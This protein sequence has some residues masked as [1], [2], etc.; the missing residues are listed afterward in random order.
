MRGSNWI[1]KIAKEG[2]W[3]QRGNTSGG[4]GIGNRWGLAGRLDST[5]MWLLGPRL[6]LHGFAH[7]GPPPHSRQLWNNTLE[8]KAKLFRV[9]SRHR[10]A[11]ASRHC[12]CPWGPTLATCPAWH[13]RYS[14]YPVLTP[15]GLLDL[16][17]ISE[18]WMTIPWGHFKRS[19]GVPAAPQG[20]GPDGKSIHSRHR[21]WW[22][23]WAQPKVYCFLRAVW[24]CA[25]ATL[26]S[27]LFMQSYADKWATD[28]RGHS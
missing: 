17:Q 18:W 3:A 11:G 25:R 10:C 20:R 5:G 13:L 28:W 4:R 26:K 21:L 12:L 6:W 23:Y 2:S 24:G 9:W 16:S 15:M 19:R 7:S 1:R 22:S 27:T 8:R 14:Y